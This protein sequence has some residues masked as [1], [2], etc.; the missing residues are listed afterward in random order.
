MPKL[1]FS[2]SKLL[3]SAA[4]LSTIASSISCLGSPLVPSAPVVP[5]GPAV[6]VPLTSQ[7][8]GTLLASLTASFSF[9]TTAGVTSGEILSAVFMNASGTLDFYYQVVNNANSSTA[10]ARE[11][12]TSFTGFQTSVAFRLDGASLPGTAFV[13]PTAG[14]LPVTAD[15]D[16]SGS[17]VGFNFVPV[18]PGTKIPA[19]TDSA[20]LVISTDATHFAPGNAE[21]LDGG[22][23]SV[24]SFEPAGAGSRVPD[25][26]STCTLLGLAFLGLLLATQ[27][28]RF[29]LASGTSKA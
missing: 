4:C 27:S 3:A 18:P 23:A 25:Q 8:A 10:I 11:A 28:P 12:N 16:A 21:V 9:T 20:V 5:G 26:S 22:V 24:A 13:N 7:S 15:R 2:G 17:T 29:V 19:G 14:I 1:S 6:G